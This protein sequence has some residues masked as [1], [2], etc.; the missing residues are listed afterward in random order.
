MTGPL[1]PVF[2]EGQVLAAADLA[3]TVEHAR[4]AAARHSRY[5]HDWGIADG[6]GLTTQPRTDPATNTRYVEVRVSP[7]FAVDGTGR[8]LVVPEAV[9]LRESD[10]EAVNGADLPTT[11]PYPVFLSAVDRTP[12]QSTRLDSCGATAG[13][14]RVEESYQVLFGRLGDERLAA[15]QQ[16]PAAGSAP[17]DPPVRWLVLLGYVRW[18]AGHFAG[19]EAKARG[20]APRYAGVRA[21]TV[22]ARSGTLTLRTSPAVKQGQPAVVLS[23]EDPP[24]LVFGLYQGNGSVSPLMT[25]A[26]NGNLSIQGS[27]SGRISVGSTLVTSGTATDGMLL[28]LPSG[29][30]PEQVAGGQVVL[31]VQL[32][33]RIPPLPAP[34][35]LYSPVEATVDGDRRVRCRV[36]LFDAA[37]TPAVV[38][39]KPGAVDFLVLAAVAAANGGGGK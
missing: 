22:T 36:R 39:E 28:P 2:H 4:G 17:A 13:Q 34:S 21:D 19:V 23:G 12:A 31:H 11:E 37:A 8:E 32:T 20:V 30:T 3:A 14:S 1:R 9:V 6:L 26:A 24:S 27:F 25:V 15:D 18:T 16:P 10:F 38:T 7:G 29:I 33:P 35:A 5:L